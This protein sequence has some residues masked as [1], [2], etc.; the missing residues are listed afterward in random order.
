MVSTLVDHYSIIHVQFLI[1][2]SLKSMR[3]ISYCEVS[4]VDALIVRSWYG[5]V[6]IV[7]RFKLRHIE[8]NRKLNA[9]K[10]QIILADQISSHIHKKLAIGVFLTFSG[11]GDTVAVD[12]VLG[13]IETDKVGNIS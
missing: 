1:I 4:S 9:R 6:H 8:E 11:V 5:A 13:E 2:S 7:S 12:E 3:Y 10:V